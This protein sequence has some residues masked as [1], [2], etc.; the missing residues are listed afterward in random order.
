M[1]WRTVVITN[2]VKLD[3]KMGYL[4]VRSKDGV[5][6]IYLDEISVLII[7]TPSVA[8][9]SYL[10][11]ELANHNVDILF[12]DQKRCPHGLYHSL[13][14]S[15]NTSKKIRDQVKWTDENKGKIW[16]EVV[17]RKILGQSAV[18]DKNG[19]EEAALKLRGYLPEVEDGDKTNREGH[20][21]K[22]Y[23]NAL[24]GK[25]FSRERDDEPDVT[26]AELN[27]GYAVL[28][29]VVSREIISNGYLTQLGIFHDNMFNEFNLAS[30]LMEPI[31][32]FVDQKVVTM[33]FEEFTTDA[34]SELVKFLNAKVM[35]DQREQYLLNAITIYIKSILDALEK[36]DSSLIKFPEYDMSIYESDSVL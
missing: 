6:R 9:T 7:E 21:A 17:I 18:L 27:Y 10:L 28:L 24:F 5:K 20:A 3:Y 15:H 25:E 13:Y 1:G 26:N 35:I 2:T 29:S 14:G 12:C 34:K 11:I 32:P 23:F 31:R 19:K 22:V 16:K 33:N 8:L 4:C 30:D 36:D